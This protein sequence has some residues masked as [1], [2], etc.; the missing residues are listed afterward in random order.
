MCALVN[1]HSVVRMAEEAHHGHIHKQQSLGTPLSMDA[2]ARRAQ[3][4]ARQ[5]SLDN[6][7]HEQARLNPKIESRVIVLTPEVRFIHNYQKE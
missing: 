1:R 5:P 4:G 7:E 3:F 6:V 2:S